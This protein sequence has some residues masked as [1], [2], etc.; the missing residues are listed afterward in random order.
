M[1]NCAAFSNG[2]IPDDEG[3]NSQQKE[4]NACDCQSR[5]G[6]HKYPFFLLPPSIDALFLFSK[7]RGSQRIRLAIIS[8]VSAIIFR[9]DRNHLSVEI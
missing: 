5:F 8:I 2:F 3:R 4:N 1:A 9:C 7:C 6:A